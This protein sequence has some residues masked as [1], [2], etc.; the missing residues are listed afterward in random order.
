MLEIRGHQK[1]D[2]PY[3]VKWLNN[4]LANRYI[5]D[6]LG[7]KTTLKQQE[8]W[9]ADYRKNRSKRFFTITWDKAPVGFMGLSRISP[10]NHNA[11]LF[12]II[13]EDDFRGKGLGRQAML[14]LMRYAFDTLRLH[15]LNLG[16]LE[17]NAHALALYQGL[18]F[19]EEGRMRDDVFH[20]EQYYDVISMAMFE[21]K[22]HKIYGKTR[23][24]VT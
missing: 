10:I 9:F 23:K 12:I 1:R 17:K 24:E 7:V 6:T 13:G 20:A 8:E 18:G 4:P 15:K 16:V 11:D 3:R 2:I 22:Y 5:G 21:D 19:Q 14:W